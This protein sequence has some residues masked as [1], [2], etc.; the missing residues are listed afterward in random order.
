M[1]AESPQPLRLSSKFDEAFL[2]AH[3]AHRDQKRK[4][5]NR[6]YISHLMGVASLVLQYG[7]DEDQAIAAL[8]HD[9]VEDCGGA[10]RLAEIREKFGERVARIV[11]GCTDSDEIPKPPWLERKQKYVERVGGEPEEVLLVSAADK[12]YNMRE[13]LM[14]LREHGPGVWER[15][16]GKRDGSLWYY[17]ALIEAFRG[18]VAKGL[19]AELERTAK[20][21]EEFG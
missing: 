4:K 9:V 21:L 20:E 13:I 19:V 14:D 7:G 1:S 11:D 5:T 12:L 3:E 6:P 16:K 17:R 15:F 18:R 2:Y 8:L 10:P